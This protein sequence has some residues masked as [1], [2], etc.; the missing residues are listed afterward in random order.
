MLAPPS[1]LPCSPSPPLS[2]A[3]AAGG[4]AGGGLSIIVSAKDS[5]GE[6]IGVAP[7]AGAGAAATA[8]HAKMA[9]YTKYREQM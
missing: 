3:A 4:H 7:G 9:K 1:R 5:K 2:I 8:E 6:E